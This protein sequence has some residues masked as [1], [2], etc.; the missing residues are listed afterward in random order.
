MS[1]AKLTIY[2]DNTKLGRNVCKIS[3][4]VEKNK[5]NFFKKMKEM[6]MS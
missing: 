3:I 6:S 2:L 5:T 1:F 4:H